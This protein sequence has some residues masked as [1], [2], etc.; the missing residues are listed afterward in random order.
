MTLSCLTEETEF[1]MIQF[2]KGRARGF[3]T[4]INSKFNKS[5]K[6]LVFWSRVSSGGR[7]SIGQISGNVQQPYSFRTLE[8]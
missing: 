2:T 6:T 8:V 1:G 7:T 4:G 5:V 3:F